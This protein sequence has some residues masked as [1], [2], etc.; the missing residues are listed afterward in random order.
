MAEVLVITALQEELDA[1]LASKA[2]GSADW[3]R[4]VTEDGYVFYRASFRDDAGQPFTL[5]ASAAA[6]MGVSAAAAHT[7]RMLRRPPRLAAMVGVCAGRRAK[8]LE[9]GDVIAADMAFRYDTGKRIGAELQPQMVA[10]SPHSKLI[11]WMN[12]FRSSGTS[13]G[14]LM[15]EP[16]PP[17]L[18]FQKQ[19]ILFELYRRLPGDAPWPAS[20]DEIVAV[21]RH[22]PDGARA[23]SRLVL[24]GLVVLTPH[25]R[26]TDAGVQQVEYLRSVE[27]LTGPRADRPDP[28]LEVGS[29]ATGAAVVES[30]GVFEELARTRDRKVLA[31]DMEAASF[32]ETM[33]DSHPYLPCTVM[34]GL[35][36]Y[37]DSEKDDGFREYARLAA[38]RVFLAFAK[39]A[40]PLI[41]D[42][43]LSALRRMAALV[44]SL[45]P[46]AKALLVKIASGDLEFDRDFD[47]AF[48]LE[49]RL[50]PLQEAGLIAHRGSV[51]EPRASLLLSPLGREIVSVLRSELDA[52]TRQEALR[53]GLPMGPSYSVRLPI[54]A[55]TFQDRKLWYAA[56]AWSSEHELTF[57]H[58]VLRGDGSGLE[59]YELGEGEY[60]LEVQ[61][62]MGAY[63]GTYIYLYVDER[64]E[65]PVW[66]SLRFRVVTVLGSADDG[67]AESLQ[68]ELVGLPEYVSGDRTLNIFT[69]GRGLGDYGSVSTYLIEG[70]RAELVECRAKGYY[71]GLEAADGDLDLD[72]WPLVDLLR[73]YLNLGE[74]L[75]G[76]EDSPD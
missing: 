40:L 41:G 21:R 12:D 33:L 20:D 38:A 32:L 11:Q 4:D 75:A 53:C 22:C 72:S 63:Q 70:G 34:K 7:M 52:S 47:R 67:L 36:D 1:V 35:S 69:K 58:S 55:L 68:E 61:V 64:S 48:Q 43:D 8:D 23:I 30:E 62:A 46:I 28:R 2:R 45:D 27:L 71:P 74:V 31:L 17:T 51:G 37:A 76:P 59:F 57:E 9:P 26:L 25:P 39:F 5:V 18:R 65:V 66:Q 19:W 13:L 15:V 73:Q 50:Q 10:A 42:E 3:D 6:K 29:F 14:S 16:R 49:A 56:V 44:R 60:L 54:P 24:E